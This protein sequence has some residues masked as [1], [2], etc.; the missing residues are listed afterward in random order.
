M[1]GAT[2][3]IYFS[4][5]CCSPS[6]RHPKHPPA[7]YP[8]SFCLGSSLGAF[9]TLPRSLGRNSLHLTVQSSRSCRRCRSRSIASGQLSVIKCLPCKNNN[10]VPTISQPR[11]VSSSPETKSSCKFLA[12]WQGP[13]IFVEQV[14]PINSCLPHPGKRKDMQL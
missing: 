6:R 11:H 10:G 7:T 12:C 3:G 9:S 2:T 4:H 8:L 14:S 5:M 1:W 13:Y